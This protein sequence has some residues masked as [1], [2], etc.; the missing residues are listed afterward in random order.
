MIRS[1]LLERITD[2]DLL[3]NLM[4]DAN[5][6]AIIML[7]IFSERKIAFLL[8]LDC[9]PNRLNEKTVW[10]V[11]IDKESILTNLHRM[12]LLMFMVIIITA[13]I[14]QRTGFCFV[15]SHG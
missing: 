3:L 11:T 13:K 2:L 12:S 15:H 6:F 8:G 4:I 10:I 1:K 14:F 9:G 7:I 5:F